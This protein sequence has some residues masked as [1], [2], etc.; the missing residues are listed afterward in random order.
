MGNMKLKSIWDCVGH[1]IFADQRF[2]KRV[3][4]TALMNS[5]ASLASIF[6][7]LLEKEEGEPSL[8]FSW[9]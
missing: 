9:S 5:L 1:I 4:P 3:L 8:A 2:K 6:S 7:E